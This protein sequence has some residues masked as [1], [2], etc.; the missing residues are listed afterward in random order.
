LSLNALTDL[1]GLPPTAITASISPAR[2][3]SIAIRCSM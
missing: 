2:I 3:F 1:Y